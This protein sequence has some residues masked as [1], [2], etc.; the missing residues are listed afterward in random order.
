MIYTKEEMALLCM[1]WIRAAYKEDDGDR[2]FLRNEPASVA[3][4]KHE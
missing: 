1:G 4:V 3:Y 2:L